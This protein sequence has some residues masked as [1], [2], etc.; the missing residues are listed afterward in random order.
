M[1][2][3]DTWNLDL[4]AK[5]LPYMRPTTR[6]FLRGFDGLDAMTAKYA[7]AQLAGVPADDLEAVDEPG[8]GI[9]VWRL[10]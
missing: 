4:A 8:G 6:I 2:A 3:T 9:S 5:T 1:T 10:S 7:I